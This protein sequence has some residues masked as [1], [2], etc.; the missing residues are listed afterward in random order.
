VW[1]V[2][3]YVATVGYAAICS[4]V[5]GSLW[6]SNGNFLDA[7]LILAGTYGTLLAGVPVMVAVLVAKQQLDASRRQHVSVI[8]RSFKKELDAIEQLRSLAKAVLLA[9]QTNSINAFS[10]QGL[11]HIP[12]P[13]PDLNHLTLWREFLSNSLCSTAVACWTI[14]KSAVDIAEGRKEGDGANELLL[15]GDFA[16]RLMIE[17]MREE[18]HLAQYWS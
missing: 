17:V 1:S 16:A 5:F 7:A 11:A 3:L 15:S 8:R 18:R 9:S 12:I 4:F 6:A 14:A 2:A 10:Q 13:F